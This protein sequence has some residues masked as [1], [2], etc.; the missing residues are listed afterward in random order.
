LSTKP[1]M[2]VDVRQFG[3]Y[4]RRYC[5]NNPGLNT[6]VEGKTATVYPGL[7]FDQDKYDEEIVKMQQ[8]L[9]TRSNPIRTR[10]K[11]RLESSQQILETRYTGLKSIEDPHRDISSK[12]LWTEIVSL[13]GSS[14]TE[15]ELNCQNDRVNQVFDKQS[16]QG[17]LVFNRVK[18]EGNPVLDP[19]VQEFLSDGGQASLQ[20]FLAEFPEAAGGS[21]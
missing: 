3:G 1:A 17:N 7:A 21:A 11:T 14:P 15:G 9:E 16:L 20:R 10:L 5:E 2:D 12:D 19:V 18:P 4:V 13:F 8:L 6:T